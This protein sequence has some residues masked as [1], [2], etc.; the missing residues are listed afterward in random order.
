MTLSEARQVA[1]MMV[2]MGRAV[3]PHKWVDSLAERAE[4]SALDSVF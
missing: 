4:E 1:E 2:M 3:P